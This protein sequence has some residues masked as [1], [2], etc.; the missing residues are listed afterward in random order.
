MGWQSC[1]THGYPSGLRLEDCEALNASIGFT[2][3]VLPSHQ[4]KGLSTA[5]DWRLHLCSYMVRAGG[6]ECRDMVRHPLCQQG[7]VLDW[8][9]WEQGPR[10]ILRMQHGCVSGISWP[11]RPLWF[12]CFPAFP[13]TL[14]TTLRKQR[15]LKC[16][17]GNN[18]YFHCSILS[19]II[20]FSSSLT[21]YLGEV[22]S[23]SLALVTEQCLERGAAVFV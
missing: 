12:I 2:N 8:F 19:D 9:G 23:H 15:K 13:W 16:P 21:A 22:L 4:V 3:V 17:C 10:V 1:E 5:C 18:C 7:L 14:T 20:W 11:K 6:A